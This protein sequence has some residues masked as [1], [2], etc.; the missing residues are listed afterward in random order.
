M[1]NQL[2]ATQQP[3]RMDRS[4]SL[5]RSL[6]MVSTCSLALAAISCAHHGS[7]VA[8]SS[9][10]QCHSSYSGACLEGDHTL[11]AP[12]PMSCSCYL[13]EMPHSVAYMVTMLPLVQRLQWA[14]VLHHNLELHKEL[15]RIRECNSRA[16]EVLFG[17]PDAG[18]SHEQRPGSPTTPSCN[19]VAFAPAS[20]NRRFS[21]PLRHWA[22]DSG[23]TA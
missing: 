6:M 9:D 16:A 10:S 3:E 21:E 4:L 12:C 20:P 2:A 22:E 19:R 1:A 23:N 11:P 15:V 13:L 14:Q 8:H 18:C 5:K 17:S 7:R